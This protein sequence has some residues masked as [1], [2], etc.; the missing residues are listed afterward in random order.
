MS[1]WSNSNR[2]DEIPSSTEVRTCGS[3]CAQS[4]RN[5]LSTASKRGYRTRRSSRYGA[6]PACP[7]GVWCGLRGAESVVFGA[8]RYDGPNGAQR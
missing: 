1:G 8:V 4:L 5:H 3:R 6:S 7:G 2:N